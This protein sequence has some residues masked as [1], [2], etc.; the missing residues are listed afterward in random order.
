[1]IAARKAQIAERGAAVPRRSWPK[2]RQSAALALFAI[3]AVAIN[4]CGELVGAIARR[5]EE[6]KTMGATATDH[7]VVAPRVGTTARMTN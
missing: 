4:S 6:F 2:E 1:M 3:A 5:R 7:G